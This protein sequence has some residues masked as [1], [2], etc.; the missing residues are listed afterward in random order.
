MIQKRTPKV[1]LLVIES[2]VIPL[3]FFEQESPVV[4]INPNR[5]K[6]SPNGVVP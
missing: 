2:P 1:S 5:P 6:E 3:F 4:P